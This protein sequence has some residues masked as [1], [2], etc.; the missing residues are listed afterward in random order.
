MGWY[1]KKGTYLALRALIFANHGHEVRV[2]VEAAGSSIREVSTGHAVVAAWGR[3]VI[4][5]GNTGDHIKSA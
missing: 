1:E 5:K 4:H 3:Y 2:L